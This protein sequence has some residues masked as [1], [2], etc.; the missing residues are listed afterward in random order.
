[1]I[2]NKIICDRCGVEI[3]EYHP[4][5]V[6]IQTYSKDDR[7]TRSSSYKIKETIHLCADCMGEFE[8][9][10]NPPELIN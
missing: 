10:I 4:D 8:R 5:R 2:I 1:M 6:V 3:K 7:V 9:F